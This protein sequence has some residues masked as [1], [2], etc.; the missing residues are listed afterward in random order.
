MRLRSD[1]CHFV[2]PGQCD[3]AASSWPYDYP[4]DYDQMPILAEVGAHVDDL[5]VS[6]EGKEFEQAM[7]KLE[8]PFR[9]GS[10][11]PPPVK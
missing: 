9:V 1:P 4:H 2:L 11:K 5:L 7:A 6:G 3:P 10:R 8:S